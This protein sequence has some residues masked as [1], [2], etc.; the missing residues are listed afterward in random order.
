MLIVNDI[1]HHSYF[2]VI[3]RTDY[4][5]NLSWDHPSIR[6]NNILIAGGCQMIAASLVRNE[7]GQG[8]KKEL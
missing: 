1:I 5:F 4:L 6:H 3:Q 8:P 2:R 7:N